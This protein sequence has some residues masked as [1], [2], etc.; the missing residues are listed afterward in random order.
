VSVE[1]LCP[2]ITSAVGE[3]DAVCGLPVEVEERGN[4]ASSDGPVPLVRTC[5]V[6]GHRLHGPHGMLEFVAMRDAA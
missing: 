6:A 2:Q 4:I 3:P 5:C 1:Y